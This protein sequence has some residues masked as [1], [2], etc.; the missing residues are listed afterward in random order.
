MN[1]EFIKFAFA[2]MVS[3]GTAYSAIRTDLVE[4]KVTSAYSIS[5]IEKIEKKLEK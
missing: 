4:L 5:R 3:S 1:L 2:V